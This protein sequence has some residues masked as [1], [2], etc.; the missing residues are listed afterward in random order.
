MTNIVLETFLGPRLMI[1]ILILSLAL[2]LSVSMAGAQDGG[3]CQIWNTQGIMTDQ[4]KCTETLK[5]D[6]VS[7][8]I[9]DYIYQWPSGAKTVIYRAGGFF[10]SLNGKS[11]ENHV[12]G[13]VYCAR[14]KHTGNT[15]CYTPRPQQAK[16]TGTMPKTQEVPA[17]CGGFYGYPTAEI[18]V[19]SELKKN[20]VG[21]GNDNAM[22]WCMIFGSH[23][24]RDYRSTSCLSQRTLSGLKRKMIQHGCSV[25]GLK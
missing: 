25:R 15:F 7:G 22:Y 1:L 6:E 8:E 24:W 17:N 5:C 10:E 23:A 20:G 12:V 9:C 19:V 16:S 11:A 3:W 2:I 21:R 18:G 13:G 14:S 4:K